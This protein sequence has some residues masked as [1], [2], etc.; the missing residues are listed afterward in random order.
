[1]TSV[2]DEIRSILAESR[3]GKPVIVASP[4]TTALQ[5]AVNLLKTHRTLT[6]SLQSELDKVNR[7]LAEAADKAVRGEDAMKVLAEPAA[8]LRKLA[9]TVNG[10]HSHLSTVLGTEPIQEEGVFAPQ[11]VKSMDKINPGDKVSLTAQVFR[12]I[13][14]SGNSAVMQPDA[15][16]RELY[17]TFEPAPKPVKSP[18][19]FPGRGGKDFQDATVTGAPKGM[20]KDPSGH[21]SLVGAMVV[22]YN[23][24]T[25]QFSYPSPK[26]PG[27]YEMA[28]TIQVVGHDP[29]MPH[30]VGESVSPDRFELQLD[31]AHGTTIIDKLRVI[32][33]G[34]TPMKV[35]GVYV[36]HFTAEAALSV[37]E[38]M[39]D[40]ENKRRMVEMTAS[41]IIHMLFR[42]GRAA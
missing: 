34:G 3:S 30:V 5:E 36:D 1:M 13:G 10:A 33:G 18:G 6:S 17:G 29:K 28:D 24:H 27:E 26:L 32:S 40:S 38:N 31:E 4:R 8:L 21:T 35:H 7:S 19:D 2:A 39:R 14:K 12:V 37:Y 22:K 15:I 9:E 25:G 41:Q 16:A 42:M 11:Y 23:P 20:L